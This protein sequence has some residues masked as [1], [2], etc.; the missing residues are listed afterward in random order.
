MRLYSPRQKPSAKVRGSRE[1]EAS[2]AAQER[3]TRPVAPA[4]TLLSSW[5]CAVRSAT[6]CLTCLCSLVSFSSFSFILF[7]VCIISSFS[8]VLA[9]HSRSFFSSFCCNSLCS[10]QEN[11]GTWKQGT[12]PSWSAFSKQKIGWGWLWGSLFGKYYSSAP[13]KGATCG[14]GGV[15]AWR[16]P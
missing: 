12:L 10:T 11:N 16:G 9:S 3:K 7:K 13:S 5:S 15:R 14:L 6:C 4:L 2:A 8:W 1:S